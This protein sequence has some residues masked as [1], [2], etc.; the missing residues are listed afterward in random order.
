MDFFYLN[1]ELPTDGF[2]LNELKF[3]KIVEFDQT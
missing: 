2:T 1:I 3:Q